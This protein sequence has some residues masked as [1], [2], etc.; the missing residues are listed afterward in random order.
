MGRRGGARWGVTSERWRSSRLSPLGGAG[1]SLLSFAQRGPPLEGSLREGPLDPLLQL[2]LC[3]VPGCGH[4]P[5]V[6]AR[7]VSVGTD[8]LNS[9]C[10]HDSPSPIRHDPGWGREYR[11][12][13][14]PRTAHAAGAASGVALALPRPGGGTLRARG[15]RPR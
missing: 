5:V 9:L 2:S 14:L 10:V 7:I 3:S 11:V 8:A 13:A 15:S 12:Q 6:S 4:G 1:P